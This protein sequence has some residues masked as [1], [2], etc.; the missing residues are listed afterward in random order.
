MTFDYKGIK[1]ICND[2]SNK[3]ALIKLL[4]YWWERYVLIKDAEKIDLSNIEKNQT[5]SVDGQLLSYDPKTKDFNFIRNSDLELKFKILS[6]IFRRYNLT[7]SDAKIY[8]IEANEINGSIPGYDLEV[9]LPQWSIRGTLNVPLT[10]EE[11]EVLNNL[12]K[13]LSEFSFIKV[14]KPETRNWWEDHKEKYKNIKLF[15]TPEYRNAEYEINS[16]YKPFCRRFLV[17]IDL[18]KFKNDPLF[19]DFNHDNNETN[20]KTVSKSYSIQEALRELRNP[21]TQKILKES[22]QV[23]AEFYTDDFDL[24]DWEE[25]EPELMSRLVIDDSDYANKPNQFSTS[26]YTVTGSL[27]DVNTFIQETIAQYGCATKEEA[28]ELYGEGCIPTIIDESKE[29]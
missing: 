9:I 7:K 8:K 3:E 27:E 11:S 23:T 1:I 2:N 20:P 16:R 26:R 6:Y 19:K 18:N 28:E 24:R 4:N 29:D 21:N 10:A 15:D 25:Y 13:K 12:M 14:K 5:F 17:N 22:K